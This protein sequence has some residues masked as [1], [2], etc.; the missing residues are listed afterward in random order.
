MEE[1]IVETW[2]IHNRINL[3]LLKS[4]SAEAL[5]SALAPKYRTVYQL[6]GHIH[7]VRLMWLKAS[8]PELLTGLEKIEG[9]DVDKEDLAK[10]LEASGKAIEGLLRKAIAAGGKVKG[11]K[12]HVVAFL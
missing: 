3:Y 7:N 6:F 9:T 5:G 11:F 10:S 8:A 1:Q 12:P 4:I 2:N